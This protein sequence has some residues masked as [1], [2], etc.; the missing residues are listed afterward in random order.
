M[1]AQTDGERQCLEQKRETHR[2]SERAREEAIAYQNEE[3]IKKQ[4]CER[5]WKRE[6]L[7]ARASDE[8]RD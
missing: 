1:R 7:E 5:Y 4:Y 8:E 2:Q 6:I 3:R